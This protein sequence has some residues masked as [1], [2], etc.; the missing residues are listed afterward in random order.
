MQTAQVLAIELW[1]YA[2]FIEGTVA[3]TKSDFVEFTKNCKFDTV[4]YLEVLPIA[5]FSTK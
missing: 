3:D 1:R 2:N 5:Q 4:R